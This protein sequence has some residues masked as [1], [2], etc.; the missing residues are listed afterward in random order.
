MFHI[1]AWMF[2]HRSCFSFYDLK[3][4]HLF[5]LFLWKAM[6]LCN[7]L[8]MPFFL[9][10]FCLTLNSTGFYSPC[11][12]S[13]YRRAWISTRWSGCCVK[14]RSF[15]KARRCGLQRASGSWNQSWRHF[16]TLSPRCPKRT[17]QLASGPL[18]WSFGTITLKFRNTKLCSELGENRFCYVQNLSLPDFCSKQEKS[19]VT[20][21]LLCLPSV[22][23]FIDVCQSFSQPMELQHSFPF[24]PTWHC[25]QNSEEWFNSFFAQQINSKDWNMLA[26]V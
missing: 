16:R 19:D 12:C 17:S 14:W 5:P 22:S 1:R 15:W 26:V 7:V 9:S 23:M 13:I 8:P 21:P 11:S 6:A 4:G 10:L 25:S 2:F 24:T 18:T 20:C 3:W